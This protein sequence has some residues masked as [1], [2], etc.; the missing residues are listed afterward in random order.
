MSRQNEHALHYQAESV[1]RLWRYT[2]RGAIAVTTI[3]PENSGAK[4][5]RQQWLND[6]DATELNAEEQVAIGQLLAELQDLPS[7]SISPRLEG[8]LQSLSEWQPTPS[9]PVKRF[10]ALLSAGLA[11]AG[12][13]LVWQSSRLDPQLAQK[14]PTP[15][16]SAAKALTTPKPGRAIAAPANKE[17]IL[18]STAS[19][20][21]QATVTIRPEQSTNLLVGKGL[22]QLPAGQTYRLWAETALGLQGCMAFRPDAEGNANIKVPREPSGSAIS[23]LISIDPIYAG[24]SSEQPGKP[25]LTSI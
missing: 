2:E 5:Q 18:T 12:A 3:Q 9:H 19:S 15:A 20:T 8:R 6:V 25:V 13:L 10:L 21:A 14:S 22:P 23:L 4:G 11:T 1:Y 16:V 17:F 7:A 24:S